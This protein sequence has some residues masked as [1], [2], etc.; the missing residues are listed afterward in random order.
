[1][2]FKLVYIVH[3]VVIIF[4]VIVLVLSIQNF[5]NSYN[6]RR[7]FNRDIDLN[8]IWYLVTNTR[9]VLIILLQLLPFI[10]V[11]LKNKFGWILIA[12]YLYFFTLGILIH[13]NQEN[14][15]EYEFLLFILS[16]CLPIISL[17]LILNLKKTSLNYYNIKSTNLL[18]YNIIS[19][20]IGFS[21]SFLLFY[22]RNSHYLG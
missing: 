9:I 1:M 17:I 10:G 4:A 12:Q 19:F 8:T 15:R 22:F 6:V 3:A 14:F 13:S 2:K 16:F 21:I 7:D 20:V 18:G 5:F 11:F